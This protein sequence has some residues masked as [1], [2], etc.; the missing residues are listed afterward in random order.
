MQLRHYLEHVYLPSRPNV[1]KATATQYAV[2]VNLLEQFAGDVTLDDLDADLLLG[3][4]RWLR[5]SGRS[6]S[7]VNGR[8]N[9]ISILWRDAHERG[10]VESPPPS[11]RK[12]PKFTEPKRLP[13]AWTVEQVR[14]L[15]TACE[16]APPIPRFK[17]HHW[18]GT[19]WRAI[20]L[21][22]WDTGHRLKAL[23][24][25][26]RDAIQDGC[27]RMP[28]EIT[29]THHEQVHELSPQTLAAIDKLPPHEM[30]FPWPFKRRQIWERISSDVLIPAGLPHDRRH[31][32]HCL[33]KSSISYV[34]AAAGEIAAMVH[35]GH[36]NVQTT[37]GYIDPTISRPAVN[38]VKL[39]PRL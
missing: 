39:L 38:A 19:H 24:N 2:G 5:D 30:L 22:I 35:A 31:K 27:L 32:F 17:P 10:Y 23:L 25:C 7:T 1:S 15:L 4:V 12:L 14:T 3:F 6:A 29:K 36:T 20:V 33:R 21:T 37:R 13:V 11:N 9:Y 18:Y 16:N 34:A 28:A 8:R 26:P